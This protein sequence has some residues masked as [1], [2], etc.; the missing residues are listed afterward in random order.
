MTPDKPETG[1]GYIQINQAVANAGAITVRR[2]VEKP[3]GI[4]AQAYLNEGGYYW[5][6]GMF[7]LPRENPANLR[8]EAIS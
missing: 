7:V 6:A 8:M 4:T 3:D 1:Y 5:N 2:F